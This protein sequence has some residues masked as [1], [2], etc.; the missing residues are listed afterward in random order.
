M[1]KVGSESTIASEGAGAR[2]RGEKDLCGGVSIGDLIDDRLVVIGRIAAGGMA[3]IFEARHRSLGMRVAIK[4]LRRNRA[5]TQAAMERLRQEARAV[6][7]LKSPYAV[8][9]LDEGV[10]PSGEAY[11]VMERL[12]GCDMAEALRR[13]GPISVAE[14]VAITLRLADAL[15]EAHLSGWVHRD[16][17]PSNVFRVA[18]DLGDVSHKLLDFGIAKCTDSAGGAGDLTDS[19]V[20]LGSLPYMSPEQVR[21]SQS[22]D[23]RTDIWSLGVTLYELVTGV[24]PFAAKSGFGVIGLI[25]E[26]V[27]APP[28][29]LRP[30][31]PPSFDAVIKRCL[32]KEPEHRY[33]NMAEVAREIALLDPSAATTNLLRRVEQ[34]YG[35]AERRSGGVDAKRAPDHPLRSLQGIAMVAACVLGLGIVGWRLGGEDSRVEALDVMAPEAEATVTEAERA[36][37][38]AIPTPPHAGAARMFSAASVQKALGAEAP[39]PTRAPSVHEQAPASRPR[40]PLTGDGFD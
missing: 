18:P 3:E 36:S 29:A 9:V 22:I 16:V 35:M 4:V 24:P 8:R 27:I 23:A 6:A 39:K 30:D 2:E 34:R 13:E 11:L 19:G 1:G 15:G 40:Y 38:V 14:A 26:G 31:L 25:L 37:S 17:K 33:S 28:S 12:E 21:S 32:A 5:L 20:V 7:M 10:L